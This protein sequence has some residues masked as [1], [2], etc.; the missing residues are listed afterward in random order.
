MH[1]CAHLGSGG[2]SGAHGLN[3]RIGVQALYEGRDFLY[4]VVKLY[5]RN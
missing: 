4:E 5:A 3:E 2:D 1:V